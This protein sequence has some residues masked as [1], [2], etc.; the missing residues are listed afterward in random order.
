MLIDL[1]RLLHLSPRSVENGLS[2]LG[3]ARSYG[4]HRFEFGDLPYSLIRELMRKVNPGPR[5]SILDLG[6]GYGR[7]GLYSALVF[8]ARY[9]GIEIVAERVAAAQRAAD[10]LELPDVEFVHADA[11]R[12]AWPS[13]T[14]V[15]LMN[16]FL[17]S[18]MRDALPRLR[19]LCHA[20]A[21]TTLAAVSTA[22]SKLSE[23]SWLAE[24]GGGQSSA[25]PFRVR[26]FHP[27]LVPQRMLFHLLAVG[28]SGFTPV[29]SKMSI[30]YSLGGERRDG[31]RV[32]GIHPGPQ[33]GRDR[34]IGREPD[35]EAR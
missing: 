32:F 20:A 9:T 10:E 28:Y 25:D 22:A 3:L 19:E 8:Q 13:A 14:C 35:Q 34:G 11:L 27:V 29:D 31:E 24:D 12:A 5:T 17:P 21:G 33:V 6:S 1:D 23:A 7:I 18:L 16:S 4:V 26:I 15:C 2:L 30:L